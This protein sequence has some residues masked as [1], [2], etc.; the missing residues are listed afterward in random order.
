MTTS[1]REQ[2][3]GPVTVGRYR[4]LSRLGEGG[5]GVVHLGLAP[6]G[7]RRAVKVL[8][9]HVVGD[10]E[11]RHRLAREVGSLSRVRSPRVAEIIDADPWGPVPFV[12]TRYVPGLSLHEHVRER[13]PVT[14]P[15]LVWLARCLAEALEAVH[16][17]GV[18]HRDVKPSNVLMEGRTPVLIDFGLARVA[19][20]SPV[21][22]TGWL[23]GT[24][25]YL[26]PEILHGREPTTSA[27][28]HSWAA[29]VAF[30]G[31]GRPPYGSGPSMAVMDRVRR[32]EHDLSGLEPAV[33]ALVA[34]CLDPDPDH[35]PDLS[36]VL[37]AL[38]PPSDR[39]HP[40]PG[41]LGAGPMTVPLAAAP[42]HE[43]TDVAPRSWTY[44]EPEPDSSP[45][46]AE[47]EPYATPPP[48]VWPERV[49]VAERA[50]RWLLA[51]SALALLAAGVGAAPYLAA[52]VVAA[53]VVALRAL[54]LTG[55][56]AEDR[57]LRRG[58][59]WYDAP[60]LVLSLPWFL[61]ASL[62]G[63]L[64][65]LASTAALVGSA[66][67]LLVLTDLG[68]PAA[69]WTLGG[70]LGLVVWTGPGSSRVR[71]PAR[72]VVLPVARGAGSTLAALALTAVVGTALVL[73][74]GDGPDWTPARTAPWV[75]VDLPSVLR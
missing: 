75:G 49:S 5:M 39:R 22:R 57:R 55:A 51:G 35:R 38:G 72:R 42:D 44:E 10:E 28:V 53:G 21:T 63:T 23:L 9:P 1:P 24:P 73:V 66:A 70:V 3:P 12:A 4:L 14:G 45:P 6:D 71:S 25:G 52:S 17:A 67:L 61:L 40:D 29:T 54:S 60:Q 8:R 15:E 48:A 18:L 58:R 13:G 32:G 36:V 64:L 37:G 46:P 34:A 33:A 30:A 2:A 68:V 56:G 69:L 59:T 41:P 62:P 50:R 43:P 19:D 27:D 74:A 65:L 16:R 7:T 26:A 31:T 47:R 11:A 20:D